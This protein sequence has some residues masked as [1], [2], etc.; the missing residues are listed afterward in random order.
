MAVFESDSDI[1]GV[2]EQ[3]LFLFARLACLSETLKPKLNG[4]PQNMLNTQS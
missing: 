1:V 4:T 3:E 2:L